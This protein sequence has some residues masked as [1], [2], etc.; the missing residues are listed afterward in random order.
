MNR[1]NR[2]NE[3]KMIAVEKEWNEGGKNCRESRSQ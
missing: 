2:V 3:L 1:L